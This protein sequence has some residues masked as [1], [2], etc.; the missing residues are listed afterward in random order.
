MQLLDQHHLYL[1]SAIFDELSMAGGE[2]LRC[3]YV[4]TSTDSVLV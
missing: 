4:L 3:F 1:N 2:V